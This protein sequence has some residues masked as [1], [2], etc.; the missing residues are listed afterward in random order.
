MPGHQKVGPQFREGLDGGADDRRKIG[1][2][3]VQTADQRMKARNSSEP[4]GVPHDIDGARVPAARHDNEAL[5]PNVYHDVPAQPQ[6]VAGIRAGIDAT[7]D[8]QAVIARKRQASE[9]PAG[10]ECCVALNKIID[11]NA[12]HELRTARMQEVGLGDVGL[13]QAS[14][15][16]PRAAAVCAF[17]TGPSVSASRPGRASPG[18][19]GYSPMTHMAAILI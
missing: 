14:P 19:D 3:Q 18:P 6:Y 11:R 5:P 16:I 8:S 13:R 2:A 15:P 12:H 10:G 4:L 17:V 1:A 7:D 9:G